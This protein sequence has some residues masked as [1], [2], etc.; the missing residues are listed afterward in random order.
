METYTNEEGAAEGAAVAGGQRDILLPASIIIAGVLVSGAILYAVGSQKNGGGLANLPSNV[1]VAQQGAGAP[2]GTGGAAQGAALNTAPTVGSRDVILGDKNAPVAVIEYADYQCPFCER[3]FSGAE[4]SIRKDYVATGK[5]KLAY[6]NFQFLGPESVAAAEAAECAKDQGAFWAYHD[7]LYRAEGIDAQEN[8]GNLNRTLF[9]KLAGDL[10]L[11]TAVFT[12][13]IDG[14]KY[15]AQVQ[16]DY[17]DAQ[18]FGINSTPIAFVGDQK[19]LGAQPFDTFKQ[20]ID[21]LL[22]K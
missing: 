8:S 7:A 16:K 18:A 11:D 13:C 15:E 6:R 2:Q 22:K 19:I 12:A 14:K 1:P 3:L 10:K 9:L 21:K 20:A 5:V 4:D 17:A